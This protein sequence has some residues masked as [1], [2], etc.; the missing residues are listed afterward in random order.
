MEEN[1]E[2]VWPDMD[3]LTDDHEGGAMVAA[4]VMAVAMEEGEDLTDPVRGQ[5][6]GVD[7]Q[8]QGHVPGLVEG[9]DRIAEVVHT[10]KAKVNPDPE[11]Q[12]VKVAAGVVV[13]HEVDLCQ[14]H[15]QILRIMMKD[16]ERLFLFS[17]MWLD[18]IDD[19]N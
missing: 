10:A 3:A 17:W 9:V 4:A 14:N 18:D 15:P 1:C 5:G 11:V 13:N 7:V 2:L 12:G 8:D 6:L 16:E 19:D